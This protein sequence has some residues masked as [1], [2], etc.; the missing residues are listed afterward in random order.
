M[1]VDPL[2]DTI[3]PRYVV[4]SDDEDEY[5][6]LPTTEH[7]GISYLDHVTEV[8]LVLE[9][10]RQISQ[11]DSLV[12]ATGDV[13]KYWARGSDL[14]QQIGAWYVNGVEVGLLFK[15][16]WIKSTI[17]VSEVSTRLPVWAKHQVALLDT[18][19]VPGY[20]SGTVL[21]FDDAPLRY[22]AIQSVDDSISQPIGTLILVPSP[23]IDPPGPKT[24]EPSNFF[25]FDQHPYDW[26]E[27]M[28]NSA[29]ELVFNSLG[30]SAPRWIRHSRN[31]GST[32]SS[33]KS[34]IGEGGMYI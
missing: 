29:Q 22:L 33:R 23:H 10:G 24:L 15:P 17:I 5:N 34:N 4:E 8:N 2:A 14:G 26:P 1:D 12:I 9:P 32:T 31:D 21:S 19:S 18:Y 30:E 27:T 28:L 3:P 16:E 7:Q 6:P 25:G 13:A 20:I 11:E